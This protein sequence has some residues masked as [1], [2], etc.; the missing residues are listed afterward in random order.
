[1]TNNVTV[2]KSDSDEKKSYA[3]GKAAELERFKA[4]M[5]EDIEEEEREKGTEKLKAKLKEKKTGNLTD[6]LRIPLG[7]PT[8][9]NADKV[10]PPWFIALQRYGPLPSY[11]SLKIAPIPEGYLFRQSKRICR[12]S[13]K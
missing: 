7:M 1:Q 13:K 11:P 6:E 4:R 9:S 5:M 2:E 8:G 10:P 12:S 3:I